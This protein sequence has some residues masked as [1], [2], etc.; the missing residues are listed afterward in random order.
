MG[1]CCS[2]PVVPP[3]AVQKEKEEMQMQETTTVDAVVES[4]GDKQDQ[5]T[6]VSAPVLLHEVHDPHVSN[7]PSR[8][9]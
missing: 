8:T 5:D 9:F 2:T 3:E 6:E 7:F 4:D 1:G